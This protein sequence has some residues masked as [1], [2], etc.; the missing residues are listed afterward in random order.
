M[1]SRSRLAKPSGAV[2]FAIEFDP[3]L[4][5]SV[6]QSTLSALAD[7]YRACGGVGFEID[8]GVEQPSATEEVYA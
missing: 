7:Y 6:I 3:S 5:P 1:L 4:S 8:F 2:D